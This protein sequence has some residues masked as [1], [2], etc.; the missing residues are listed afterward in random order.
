MRCL[1]LVEGERGIAIPLLRKKI[2]YIT[3]RGG[4]E[5]TTSET[6]RPT[7]ACPDSGHARDILRGLGSSPIWPN[8]LGLLPAAE[9][10]AGPSTGAVALAHFVVPMLRSPR[11]AVP[12]RAAPYWLVPARG[13]ACLCPGNQLSPTP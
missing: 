12:N 5:A 11:N 1:E 6:H 3:N 10:D 2:I 4:A 13:K 7:A 8:F 9:R